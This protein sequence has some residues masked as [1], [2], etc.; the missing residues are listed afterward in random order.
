MKR[1]ELALATLGAAL[2]ACGA[3]LIARGRGP[4]RDVTLDGG[5]ACPAL[6]VRVLEPAGG[7]AR[8]AAV[9]F[10]GLGAN[11]IVMLAT[12]QQFATAG[13]RVYLPDLPGHGTDSALFSFSACEACARGLLSTLERSGAITA[14]ETVLVGHS[15]GAALAV[16]LVDF[17]PAAA[18]IAVA[19]APLV[20]PR[21]IPANLLLVAPQFDMPAVLRMERELAPAAGNAR[22]A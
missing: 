21:R 22:T 11:R 18:T 20:P 1:A 13:L 10:H 14:R 6:P 16:R 19:T 2:L 4:M 7:N 12:G 9:I 8:G 3:L 5:A 15:M 17:F